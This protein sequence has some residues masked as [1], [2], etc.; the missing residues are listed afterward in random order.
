MPF[1]EEV[2][3]V[4]L[5][6]LL[7]ERGVLSVPENIRR[8]VQGGQRLPDITVA[9]MHGVRVVVEG[10]SGSGTGVKRTLLEDAQRRVE[11]G[12]SPVCLAVVYPP[13][14]RDAESVAKLKRA[15][16]KA[17]LIVRVVSESDD[18]DWADATADGI[19]DILRRAYELL[20]SED[21]VIRAV[22]DL[23]G[24]I[25]VASATIAS[26][27]AAPARLRK[28]LGIPSEIGTARRSRSDG[29]D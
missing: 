28:L 22:E 23:S 13:D 29:E 4:V 3:N 27:P 11:E 25:G 1:R 6:E 5:A 14:L 24:A 10:R 16:S 20:V 26:A 9:D 17:H 2:L 7:T 19:A 8:S 18:G 12:I 15:L 21:V